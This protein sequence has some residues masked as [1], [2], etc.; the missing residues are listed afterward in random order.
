[1]K[2][3]LKNHIFRFKDEIR[4]QANGGAI[5]VKAAGDIA[6]LFMCWWDKVFIEKVNEALQDLNLYL[7]YVDDEY[8]ICEIIPENDENREQPPDER[9]MRKPQG[10]VSILPSKS[11]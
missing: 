11:Q 4:K 10:I 1:M 6:S 9:T 5:G 2:T 7:R 3:V 8:V